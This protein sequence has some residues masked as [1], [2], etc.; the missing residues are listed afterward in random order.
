[1]KKHGALPE[2]GKDNDMELDLPK[3]GDDLGT[4]RELLEKNLKWSQI[5][6]EQNRKIN[7][8]LLWAAIADWIRLAFIIIPFVLAVLYLPPIVRNFEER[9]SQW[10]HAAGGAPSASNISDLVN[11]LPLSNDQR[12][13]VKAMMH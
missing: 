12:E 1:M 4:M 13:Q 6:Y 3:K 2:A 9:Y 8:K 5:I 7:N 10:L 11:L